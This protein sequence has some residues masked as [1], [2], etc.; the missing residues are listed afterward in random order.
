MPPLFV[1][2]PEVIANSSITASSA[3]TNRRPPVRR[4]RAADGRRGQRAAGPHRPH[5][6]EAAVMTGREPTSRDALAAAV[7]ARP[8]PPR[9]AAARH[10]AFAQ[11]SDRPR[12]GR[13]ARHRRRAHLCASA[14]GTQP[15]QARSSTTPRADPP[16]T[17]WP[18][19]PRTIAA[20]AP[21]AAARAGRCPA[22]SAGRFSMLA[23]QPRRQRRRTAPDPDEQRRRRRSRPPGSSRLFAQTEPAAGRRISAVAPTAAGRRRQPEPTPPVDAAPPRTCRIAR[24]LS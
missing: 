3:T 4:R 6:R 12:R 10:A 21:G 24:S 2:G 5:R 19:C 14:R 18:I 16:P 1:I 11:G 23:R 9:R 8:A 17:A 7:H 13:R 20:A 22:I 15:A